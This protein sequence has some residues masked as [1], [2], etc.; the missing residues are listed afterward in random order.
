MKPRRFIKNEYAISEEFTT[1]PALSVVMIGFTIFFVLMANTYGAYEN[2]IDSLEKYKTADFIATKLTNPD[3]FFIKEG[4][5]LDLPL[6]ENNVDSNDKLN[7]MR[8]E[9]RSCGIDF[10]VRISWD[11]QYKDF[12]QDLPSDIGNRVAVSKDVGV[13]INQAQTKPGKLTIISWEAS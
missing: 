7:S 1:L 2:R 8:K 6:L 10:I 11:T 4:G 5:I 3:C 13:Y 9:Y 12:P